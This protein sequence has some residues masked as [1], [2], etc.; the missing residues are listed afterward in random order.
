MASSNKKP[1]S[2]YTAEGGRAKRITPYLELR[3][4]VMSCLLFEKEFYESG[5]SIA[6]RIVKLVGQV[7]EEKAV[8]IASEAR[9]NFYLRHVP[10][11]IADSLTKNKSKQV[12]NLLE[13]II[14]RP[15]ELAEFLAIYWRN[16][17]SPISAQ[18][19][20]GLARAFTK[21]NRYSLAKYNR[22]KA[23][24][25]RD[26][27]FLCHAK[28]KNEQQTKDWKDL[29]D[30]TLETPDTWEVALSAGKNKKE[31][32]ERLIR[33]GKLGGLATLRN[34]RNFKDANVERELVRHAIQ[35]MNTDKILPYR[36]IAAAKYAP[37]Y[38]PDL[39]Q[40]MFG[41]L[42]KHEK[43]EGRT[44]LLVDVS[45]SM[46]GML[47]SKSDLNRLDAACGLAM[48]LREIC[49][50]ISIFTFSRNLVSVPARRGFALSD[51]INKSQPHTSTHLGEA[52]KIIN[53]KEKYHRIIVITDEQ[54]HDRVGDPNGAG[55]M[56]NVASN[57]N[58][59]GYGAWTHIDGFSEAVV[60]YIMEYEKL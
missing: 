19:K 7:D 48:L 1:E 11:L 54:S 3:R 12:A 52:L 20:K 59:V 30:G 9:N 58:G 18:A 15:D 26:V 32:W 35:N 16:G 13:D 55:Y 39:E 5:E 40:T 42:E 27:L 34:L 22:D 10:L 50:D 60:D 57:K 2:I 25:L 31:T 21:F 44:I 56:I 23:I 6:D 45:G 24:K 4:S 37:D 49:Y 41:C 29:V 43:M 33:E 47:S 53:Q 8:Q 17:K 14:Q 46:G 28:P 38:E 51:A 36:F